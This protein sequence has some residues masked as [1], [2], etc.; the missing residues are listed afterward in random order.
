MTAELC[1]LQTRLRFV[2]GPPSSLR[3][4]S[5]RLLKDPVLSTPPPSEAGLFVLLCGDGHWGSEPGTGDRSLVP[6]VMRRLCPIAARPTPQPLAL[7][8]RPA[9]LHSRSRA[10]LHGVPLAP[11]A[12]LAGR[13]YFWLIYI[14]PYVSGGGRIAPIKFYVCFL[15]TG[16]T[17]DMS[18]ELSALGSRVVVGSPS[19]V[20]PAPTPAPSPDS[21]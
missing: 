14:F 16:S 15:Q 12:A 2:K 11:R 8:P 17:V 6:I 3:T 5:F 13:C 21:G 20:L 19:A 10:P 4:P 7:R 9:Q 18:E 1:R